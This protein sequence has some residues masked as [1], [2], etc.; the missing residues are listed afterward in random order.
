LARVSWSLVNRALS[1]PVW[2]LYQPPIKAGFPAR[3]KHRH[4]VLH[5]WVYC[6]DS[7]GHDCDASLSSDLWSAGNSRNTRT[8]L[9]SRAGNWDHLFLL[10]RSSRVPRSVNRSPAL[11]PKSGCLVDNFDFSR[12]GHLDRVCLLRL[13]PKDRSSRTFTALPFAFLALGLL[14]MD[15]LSRGFPVFGYRRVVTPQ[16]S[17]RVVAGVG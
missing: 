7:R 11:P 12:V 15:R 1:D 2:R 13:D 8:H 16:G 6:L 9:C 5:W 4:G 10:V 17:Q 14:G 3:S